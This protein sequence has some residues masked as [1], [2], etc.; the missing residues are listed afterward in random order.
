M[1][2]RNLTNTNGN[3]VKN[4]FV[5]ENRNTVSFQSYESLICKIDHS[6]GMGFSKVVTFG[7]DWNFSKTTSKHLFAFLTQQG[8]EIL[9]NKKT[10]EEAI[11][12]G[13]ARLDQGIAVWLDETL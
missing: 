1:K 12:R 10:I 8:L 7:K 4:Q 6:G 5:I 3:A 2:I 13:Y 9:A 11:D